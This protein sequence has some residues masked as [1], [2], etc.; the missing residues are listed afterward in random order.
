MST[1]GLTGKRSDK[2]QAGKRHKADKTLKTLERNYNIRGDI[3]DSSCITENEKTKVI[4][5]HSNYV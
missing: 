2:L 4:F 1:D 3:S 5:T